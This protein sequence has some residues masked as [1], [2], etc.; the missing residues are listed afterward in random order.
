MRRSRGL[1][2]ALVLSLAGA[3]TGIGLVLMPE[4][5]AITQPVAFTADDLPTWQ[6]NGIVFAMAQANGTVF[7]G[8][9]FSAVRPPDN[10]GS[11]TEQEA[12]NFVALDAATGNPTSCKLA[13]TTGDGSATV[14]SLVVSKDNKTLYAAGYFGAVNGTPVSSVAAIDIE[15]CTPKASFHPSFPAT[16]RALAVTDDTLYAAGDFGTVEGQTRERFA[17][18]DAGSGAI[19]PFVANAD[20]PGRAI[21]LSNDGKNVLLGGDFFSVNGSNTHALAVV[22]ATTGA[23]AKTYNNIP[24]NSVV[25]HISADATGYYTGNEGS[26]GGVFDGRIGLATNFNEKW[27]DRCLGATQFVLPYDGVLYSSSHAHDCSLEGQF[28]D[29]KRNFLLAQLTDHEGAAPAPVDGFVRSPRKLGWHPTANDGLGEGIGPRVMA[30]AEKNETKYMW[31]GGEFTLINGQPQQALTRFSSKGDV[32]APTTPVASAGSVKPGEAQVRWRTSYDQDD[33]K[34]TYRIYRNGSGTPIATVAAESLEWERPQASWIDTT[35]KAGQSYTYRVTATDGAGNTS[36]LSATSSVTIPSS[37][38][39]YPDK[40][41]SDG[42]NLYWRYDDAV[43]PY[44]ADSSASGNTSG[45][46]VNAPA[47]RQTPGAVAGTG[48]AMGFNGTSQQVYSDHRQSVG[49]SYTIETW[50]KTNSSR[51]G[52]L[53]G[54]G[55]NTTSNS[56]TYDKQLYITNTGRLIF[57]VYNGSNRTI[58]TGLFDSSYNDNKWH[59]VVGTQGPGGMTLYVDGQNK[60]TNNASTS[61]AYAG[62]WHVGGDNLAGWP[63]RPTSNFFA[64]QIDETAVYPTALT[65]AQVKAHFDLAKAPTD[66]VSKVVTTE[67]TYV[68][69]GAPNAANGAATSLA[70]RGTSAYQTYLRFTLP[71]APAGQ[72]LKAASLQVKTTTQAGAGTTDTVS[73]VPVTGSWTAAATTF[74]TKPALGTPALGTLAGA[75]DG[76]AIHGID[77]DT[78]AVTALLGDNTSLAL[79]ST[80]TDPLWLWS[81]EST[82]ADAAPQLILTFGPK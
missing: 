51:G 54:F 68:N 15:T 37:V 16:V 44:V 42:A 10:A 74:N 63:T 23:V 5:S 11:G 79:T 43:S 65:Q 6:P 24:S 80:G 20:E 52:K 38:Q 1:T 40:V 48:T 49:S 30:I 17:A 69:Q 57:G 53:I 28:P 35:V 31:V 71:A 4:A 81:S 13:F 59:H 39:S 36:A 73:V 46:Q 61:T 76:S 2:A 60:G 29:G 50:F 14:R 12:V 7:A 34:L 19:K 58:S 41:R 67:D 75:A 72:V 56:G 33:S 27:R 70:V 47:L 64:G 32:G 26:G 78:A 8:G 55:N 21:A 18:V 45:I 62:F 22:N 77:L 66:T 82:A 3:G 25:K 9:T